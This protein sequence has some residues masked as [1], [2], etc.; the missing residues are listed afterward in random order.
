[1]PHDY[2]HKIETLERM[3]ADLVRALGKCPRTAQERGHQV[4]KLVD[5]LVS[6]VDGAG[7]YWII[8]Y[9]TEMA[10]ALCDELY[11]S[12]PVDVPSWPVVV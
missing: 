12:A 2:E 1:M 4:R 8:R 11:G 10:T 9:R 3:N 6:M 5:H 7:G